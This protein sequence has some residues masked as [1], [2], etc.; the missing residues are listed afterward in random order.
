MELALVAVGGG[1]VF[2]GMRVLVTVA[3]GVCVAA[4]MTGVSVW[5]LVEEGVK[6]GNGVG[7]G[8]VGKGVNVAPPKLNKGVAVST[9]P[10]VG[11][12]LGLGEMPG[13]LR[14]RSKLNVTEQR[15]QITSKNRTGI[16]FGPICPG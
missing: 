9:V 8:S 6:V 4:G 12:I 16:S 10:S 15:Q 1:L 14:G 5:V 13:E 11:K 3:R 7:P 2:V